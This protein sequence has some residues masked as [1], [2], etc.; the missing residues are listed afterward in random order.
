VNA[1]PD[2]PTTLASWGLAIARALQARDRDPA[3]LFSRAGLDFEALRDPNARYPVSAIG[4]LWRLAVQ[5]TGDP[6]LG[7]AVARHVTPTTFHALGFSL[8]SSTTLRDV[9]ERLVRYF[10]L[11]SDAAVIRLEDRGESYRFAVLETYGAPADE[12]VDALF[13]CAVRLCRML[14]DRQFAPLLVELRRPTP[15]DPT[16]FSKCFRAPL[17]FGAAQNALTIDKRVCEQRLPGANPEAAR[18]ND[19]V[20]AQALHR[21]QRSSCADRVRVLLV[22]R[23]PSGEPSQREIA[24]AVASS[25]RA[26][27]RRLAAEGTTY[28]QLVDETRR[29]LALAYMSDTRYSLGEIAYLLGF[30]GGNNFARAFRRWTGKT[31]SEYRR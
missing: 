13:A 3:P 12:G 31:P 1:P 11:V 26:L 21:M 22:E 20:V 23:L 30:S 19:E 10:R 8:S 16:P 5:E 4:R 14:S 15:A 6:A 7:L 24:R 25:T 29:E 27:Q 2:D 9:F 28:T 17:A 18:V